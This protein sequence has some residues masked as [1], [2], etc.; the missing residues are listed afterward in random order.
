MNWTSFPP[1]YEFEDL[2]GATFEQVVQPWSLTIDPPKCDVPLPCNS[3]P[4]SHFV[5]DPSLHIPNEN[6]HL[7]AQISPPLRS[8]RL[9]KT[10]PWILHKGED[11]RPSVTHIAASASNLAPHCGCNPF[12]LPTTFTSTTSLRLNSPL[13]ITNPENHPL[14][15]LDV[16]PRFYLH[17]PHLLIPHRNS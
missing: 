9:P 2:T 16:Y 3:Y 8:P 12:L 11:P 6:A 7:N 14:S 17:I 10:T 4:R 15:Y 13:L 5:L 1:W